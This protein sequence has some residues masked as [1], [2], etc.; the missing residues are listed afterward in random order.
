MRAREILSEIFVH[1]LA[2]IDP[3]LVRL[4]LDA[5]EALLTCQ[6][7]TLTDLGRAL[8]RDC[9]R[10]HAVKCMDR[11]LKNPR[12]ETCRPVVGGALTA[13]LF[14][15]TTTPLLLV[16]WT[17]AGPGYWALSAA[18]PIGGRAIAVYHEV[19]PT[20]LLSN[21]EVEK[22]F[23][24]TL[25]ENVVPE[26]RKPIVV[27]DSGF[28]T[29]WFEAV[30]T[31]NWDYLGRL[32][33]GMLVRQDADDADGCSPWE[34]LSTIYSMAQRRPDD[35]GTHL[36][37]RRHE[38]S[39]RLVLHKRPPKGRKAS[40]KPNRKG[41]HPGSGAAQKA[42]KRAKE[43]WL[44][45]TSLSTEDAATV[46]AWYAKRFQIEETFRDTKSHRFGFSFEDAGSRTERRLNN[47]LLIAILA[48]YTTTVLG[49]AAESEGLD[50]EMQANTIR[51]RRVFS[52]F[53]LGRFVLT[54][55]KLFL[56]LVGM[57]REALATL[58]GLVQSMGRPAAQAT[59]G[60]MS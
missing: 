11:L 16:D 37:T 31:V 35:L 44:L 13:D 34:T 29:P 15:E 22:R 46:V 36:L 52:L 48:A 21:P 8:P 42:R 6:R 56:R 9:G 10:K 53:T 12:I 60:G 23:L 19:H 32:G 2:E 25:K 7:L 59:D 43:P 51:N 57:L 30:C 41:V 28:G 1:R 4:L 26:D 40:R 47:L 14:Q 49:V 3:R 55:S 39:S 54:D 33:G 27:T 24:Q 50:R 38:F 20:S 5:V 17:E 18:T 58:R 45:A